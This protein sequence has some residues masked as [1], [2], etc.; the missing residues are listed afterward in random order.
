MA[1]NLATKYRKQLSQPYTLESVIAGRSS[2]A[3]D[4]IGTKT[5]VL[6]TVVTQA[7]GNYK[8]SGQ[9][10]FGTPTEVQDTKQELTL[11]QDKAYS[12]TI[13]RGNYEDQVMAKEAG[14]V[15][16]AQIAEQCVPF[17]DKYALSTWAAGTK[18]EKVHATLDKDTVY[19]AI[20]EA[21]T[22][23]VNNNIK[24]DPA[25]CTCYIGSSSYALLLSNSHFVSAD[26]LNKELLTKGVV[27]MCAGFLIVEVP[28]AYLPENCLMLFT[29]KDAVIAP[30]KLHS[31]YIRNNV[32]GIDGWVIEGRDYGDAFI[33]EAKK[34]G[35][36]KTVSKATPEL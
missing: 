28:D 30:R 33:V 25:T 18:N 13:D 2:E 1:V 32:Q 16:K 23:F 3:Y 24:I 11:T 9:N 31:L 36:F 20:V 7:L 8:R 22:A 21:R 19:T 14:K 6:L 15:S 10:R 26:K 34:G 35:V 17:W 12:I 5:I 27:G 4:W 29:H